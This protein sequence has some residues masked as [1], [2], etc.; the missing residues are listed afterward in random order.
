MISYSYIVKNIFTY[1]ITTNAVDLILLFHN[2]SSKETHFFSAVYFHHVQSIPVTKIVALLN[3]NC[4]QRT[5]VHRLYF[6][7]YGF[8][9]THDSISEWYCYRTYIHICRYFGYQPQ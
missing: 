3:R 8:V 9:I 4:E 1:N 2:L 6:D 5:G 7:R